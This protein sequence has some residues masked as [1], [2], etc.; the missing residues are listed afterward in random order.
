[1]YRL[2][3][4]TINHIIYIISFKIFAIN[5]FNNIIIN[6]YYLYDE[7]YYIYRKK[8]GGKVYEIK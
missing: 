1:M 4:F 6:R 2:N 5:K 3:V 8:L 7:V